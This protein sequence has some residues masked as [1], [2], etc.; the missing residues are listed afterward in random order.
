M[1]FVVKLNQEFSSQLLEEAEATVALSLFFVS[2]EENDYYSV[3]SVG[4]LPFD[5]GS[6]C[7]RSRLLQG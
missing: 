6:Y 4:Q 2:G 3:V 7:G 5:C 1:L